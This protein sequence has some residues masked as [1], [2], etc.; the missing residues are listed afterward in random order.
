MKALQRSEYLA[1]QP[2]GEI[3]RQYVGW[4]PHGWQF[5]SAPIPQDDG[6][7]N[8]R[9]EKRYPLTPAQLWERWQDPTEVIGC[10]FA[11]TTRYGMTDLDTTGAYVDNWEPVLRAMEEKAGL[12][13]Y[14]LVQSSWSGGKHVYFPVPEDVGTWEMALVL[15]WALETSGLVVRDGQLETFPHLK[16]WDSQYKAHA[17]PLQPGRGSVLLNK[18]GEPVSS[19][20]GA[21][22]KAM[23]AEAEQQDM[24][25]FKA[26]IAKAKKWWKRRGRNRH[27][28][29][30][31]NAFMAD[32][33]TEM[34]QGWTGPAQSNRLIFRCLQYGYSCLRNQ[35]EAL[36]QWALKT[37]PTLPGF[38]RWCRTKGPALERWIRQ[39]VLYLESSPQFFIPN[40]ESSPSPNKPSQ[41]EVLRNAKRLAIEAA[42]AQIEASGELFSTVTGLQERITQLS[43]VSKPTCYKHRDLWHPEHRKV[44][45]APSGEALSP[46]EAPSA[47]DVE[48]IRDLPETTENRELLTPSPLMKGIGPGDAPPPSKN[49]DPAAKSTFQPVEKVELI[50][51]K[52]RLHELRSRYCAAQA[53]NRPRDCARIRSEIAR[54]GWA[55][56]VVLNLEFDI[57]SIGEGPP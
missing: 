40:F 44:L 51:V 25:V 56:G 47:P 36:V 1:F 34:Q 28:E 31:F 46:S 8:Y 35:G 21:W 16:K 37:I 9:T 50:E 4:F 18:A 2:V 33:E 19:S 55:P 52:R 20:P 54:L 38:Q 32:L 5:I 26:A 53:L 42:M 6:K 27:R 7:P 29:T 12:S 17:L 22:A 11:S 45:T 48:D 57:S 41:N 39:K 30:K 23:E 43:G 3:A 14:V 10:S 24:E 15:N 13:G 49:H